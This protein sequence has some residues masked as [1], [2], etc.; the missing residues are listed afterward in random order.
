MGR[1]RIG[2]VRSFRL[3]ES[4]YKAF[5]E[6]CKERGLRPTQVV[7]QLVQIYYVSEMRKELKE[8]MN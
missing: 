4:D 6:F 3:S 2:K 7:R 1:K 5:L 8:E